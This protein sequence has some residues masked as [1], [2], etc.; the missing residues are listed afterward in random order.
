MRV[1]SGMR[2]VLDAMLQWEGYHEALNMLR[3]II[4]MQ[5]EL[6]KEAEKA[7]VDRAGDVFED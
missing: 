1:V 6:A 2:A 5:R 3:E 4:R 7:A